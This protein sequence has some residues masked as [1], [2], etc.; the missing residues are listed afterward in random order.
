VK[1][2]WVFYKDAPLDLKAHVDGLPHGPDKVL[3][4]PPSNQ[5]PLFAIM[6]GT[7]GALFT[8]SDGYKREFY[9]QDGTPLSELTAA[10]EWFG[11]PPDPPGWIKS[12]M[13]VEKEG[14]DYTI[15]VTVVP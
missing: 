13:I 9:I 1:G 8:D 7:Y 5:V 10:E 2:G 14:H 11:S 15:R 3:P 4:W 12:N 6:G